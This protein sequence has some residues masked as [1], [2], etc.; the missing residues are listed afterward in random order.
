[1][2]ATSPHPRR[3]PRDEVPGIAYE[4][5]H[6]DRGTLVAGID[7][8]GR[9]AWAGPLTLAAVV[10]P[11]ERR[12]YK[13]RDSKQL[14]PAVRERLAARIH[15]HAVGVGIG[16]ASNAEIDRS[17]LSA[18]MTLAARRALAAL[19]DRPD[20]VLLDGQWDFLGDA[21][22]PTETIVRGD[23]RCAS[24]AAAS[25]VAKV[26]RDRLLVEAADEHPAYGFAAN[27]GYPSPDH[28]AALDAH[29]PC[30]LHR[31]SWAPIVARCH[32]TLFDPAGDPDAPATVPAHTPDRATASR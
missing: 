28:I 23:A 19:P 17:G 24:I 11:S 31:H 12:I 2:P 1:M 8:V 16:H 4:R 18:A 10:L 5:P 27:K 7:E 25:I 22:L 29:G 15:E 20:A 6:W 13:L 14:T 30:E 26:T 3:P 32:P 9:G 21:S